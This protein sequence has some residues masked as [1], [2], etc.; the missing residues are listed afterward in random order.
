MASSVTSASVNNAI[1]I[2]QQC[3]GLLGTGVEASLTILDDAQLDREEHGIRQA[4]CAQARFHCREGDSL[5][6]NF[7]RKVRIDRD[8]VT[9]EFKRARHRMATLS[10][11][12]RMRA[13]ME[14][15]GAHQ[16]QKCPATRNNFFRVRDLCVWGEPYISKIVSAKTFR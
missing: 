2:I 15:G 10:W 4:F 13:I 12:L 3:H 16:Y 11:K 14:R 1:T 6:L 7:N 5:A 9:I 8:G